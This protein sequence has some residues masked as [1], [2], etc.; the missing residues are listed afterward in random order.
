M[1]ITKFDRRGGDGISAQV[2]RIKKYK[3]RE[4]ARRK[5]GW[6]LFVIFM[7]AAF[8]FLWFY[9]GATPEE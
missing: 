6:V 7:V 5:V 8:L 3:E 1:A 4:L 9:L 2:T